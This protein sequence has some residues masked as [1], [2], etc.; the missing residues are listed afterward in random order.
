MRKVILIRILQ[1]L[2]LILGISLAFSGI[3]H[4]ELPFNPN[5]YDRV[6][7][8]ILELV[9]GGILSSQSAIWLYKER[10]RKK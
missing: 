7:V 4:F 6:I 9:G 10:G 1:T 5:D 3:W 8:V 2:R